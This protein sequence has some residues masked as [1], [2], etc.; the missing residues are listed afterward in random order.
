[1]EERRKIGAIPDY[2]LNAI[3]KIYSG[4]TDNKLFETVKEWING[5]G[6][7][8]NFVQSWLEPSQDDS[9]SH[10]TSPISV[11]DNGTGLSRQQK[12]PRDLRTEE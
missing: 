6:L 9:G 11:N 1:M 3:A 8:E 10:H 5:N 2:V 7:R 12:T 4:C